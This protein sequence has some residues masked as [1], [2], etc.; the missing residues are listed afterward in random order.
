MTHDDWVFAVAFSPDGRW[1]V[2]GSGDGTARVWDAAT[3]HE[4]ARMTHDDLVCAVAFSPDGRWVVSG[5]DDKT[6]RVW[7]WQPEELIVEACARLD[8]NLTQDEWKKYL[9][10]APYRPTCP[11]LPAGE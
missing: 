6:A 9:P 7:L 5:S 8:R 2:S 11:K 10:D 4:V 1:V 3:G